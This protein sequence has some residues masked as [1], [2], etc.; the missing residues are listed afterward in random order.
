V[1]WLQIKLDKFVSPLNKIYFSKLW[2]KFGREWTSAPC[3]MI[4]FLLEAMQDDDLSDDSNR[5]A[6]ESF[7]TVENK[8][9]YILFPFSKVCTVFKDFFLII[10]T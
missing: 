1:R 3:N 7:E 9:H 6:V 5:K 2:T 8:E 4:I 10:C